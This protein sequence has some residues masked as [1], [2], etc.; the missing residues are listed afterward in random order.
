MAT[1]TF[2]QIT[3][4]TT[5]I[6]IGDGTDPGT[7]YQLALGQWAPRVARFRRSQLGG[8]GP[9]DDVSEEMVLN[10]YGTDGAD[11]LANLGALAALL[12]QADRWSYGESVDIVSVEYSPAGATVSSTGSPLKSV[13]LGRSFDDQ[14]NNLDLPGDIEQVDNRSAIMGVVVRFKRRGLW[15][16]T[17]EAEV[18]SST[19]NGDLFTSGTFTAVPDILSPTKIDI[20]K[21]NAGA[22]IGQTFVA[23]SDVAKGIIIVNPEAAFAGNGYAD[24]DDSAN[25]ARNTDVTRYTP[26]DTLETEPAGFYDFAVS[27]ETN[28]NSKQF[29]IFAN[30]RNNSTT[31][32]FKVRVFLNSTL[33]LEKHYTPHVVIDPYSGSAFPQWTSLGIIKI[34]TP[35]ARGL[36]LAITAS[37]ASGTIDIDTIVIVDQDEGHSYIVEMN[38][39]LTALREAHSIDHRLLTHLAPALLATGGSPDIERSYSGDL[40]IHTNGSIAYGLLMGTGGNDADL[41]RQTDAVPAVMA[42]VLTATRTIGYLTPT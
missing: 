6:V 36:G 34:D 16:H 8:R 27:S 9:Y 13:I 38:E 5:D 15:L 32:S 24:F 23:I 22:N 40:S 35:P 29:A 2:L 18:S 14:T 3:D 41:W 26:T 17:D 4:G 7:D 1:S 20:T 42:C 37:A 12:D 33:S 11:C 10:I 31:T 28:T 19:T 21:I 25:N 30:I 39:S